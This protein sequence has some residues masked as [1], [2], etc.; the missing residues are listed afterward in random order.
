M[1]GGGKGREKGKGRRGKGE[2]RD[3]RWNKQV[4]TKKFKKP[5]LRRD[6]NRG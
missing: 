5:C 6:Y 1:G 3:Y 4:H 2:G